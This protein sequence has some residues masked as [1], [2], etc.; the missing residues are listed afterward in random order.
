[1]KAKLK[2]AVACALLAAAAGLLTLGVCK[3]GFSDVANK[4]NKVCYECV[5]IG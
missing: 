3:G 5:G 2:T 1:M 4:A